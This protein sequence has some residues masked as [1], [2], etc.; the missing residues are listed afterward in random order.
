MAIKFPRMDLLFKHKF[1]Q[2]MEFNESLYIN[3]WDIIVDQHNECYIKIESLLRASCP[4]GTYGRYHP[5]SKVPEGFV[6][7]MTVP[8]NWSMRRTFIKPTD[9]LLLPIYGLLITQ[10]DEVEDNE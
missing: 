2:E 6:I 1:P 9:G 4:N 8:K 7:N 10:T 5:I 3:E